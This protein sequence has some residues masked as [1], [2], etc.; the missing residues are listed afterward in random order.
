MVPTFRP[1]DML[2]MQRTQPQNIHPG[3]VVSYRSSRNPNELV[4]HRVV[5]ASSKSFQTKGDALST[6][7]P[8]VKDSLLVGRVVAVLPR[9]GRVLTWVQ[10][11][12][13][14]VVCVYLPAAIIATQ[15]LIRLERAYAK[16]HIYRL[17]KMV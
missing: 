1:G 2:I 6:P 7:D 3:T 11:V 9:M 16:S 5:Q 8:G 10:S 14:L 13:G 4:T 15:E 12:P 17:R